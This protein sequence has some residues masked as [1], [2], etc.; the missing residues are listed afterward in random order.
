MQHRL[1]SASPRT[2]A[3]QPHSR[4]PACLPACTSAHS[5]PSAAGR[6]RRRVRG[7]VRGD[8]DD[9]RAGSGGCVCGLQVGRRWTVAR[10][11]R[12]LAEGAG[13]PASARAQL[14]AA[15]A[16]AAAAGQ[17]VAPLR[18]GTRA[19]GA[20]AP[21]VTVEMARLFELKQAGE[22]LLLRPPAA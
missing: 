19:G 7:C 1:S 18:L 16:A 10:V 15:A 5:P 3:H 8:D 14:Q 20:L 6:L 17:Q 22:L 4:L 11:E 12:Q 21:E 2:I 9:D 13:L